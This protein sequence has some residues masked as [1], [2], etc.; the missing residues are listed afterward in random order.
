MPGFLQLGP[1]AA[2]VLLTV[3]CA[4]IGGGP[5]R[6]A[7]QGDPPAPH[8]NDLLAT[9]CGADLIELLAER[10]PEVVA[11]HQTSP[12]EFGTRWLARVRCLADEGDHESQLKL[13][14]VY[15]DGSDGPPQD[16]SEAALWFRRAA[17][18]ANPMA[19][20]NLGLLYEG[21]RGVPQNLQH[22][23]MW[24]NLAASGFDLR[25]STRASAFRRRDEVASRM[26]SDDVLAAQRMASEW[27]AGRNRTEPK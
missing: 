11:L 25:D 9:R 13:G 12:Q 14:I 3:A 7:P 16:Y 23:H 22:A 8:A 20:Y 21:G 10:D 19:Q 1:V 6:Q 24:Y 26:R 4:S 27:W 15:R 17:E 5:P 2:A 18:Q